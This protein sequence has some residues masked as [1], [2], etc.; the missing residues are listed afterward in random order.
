MSTITVY[1]LMVKRVAESSPQDKCMSIWEEYNHQTGS[2]ETP[3]ETTTK[4]IGIGACAG[5]GAGAGAATA[6][7]SFVDRRKLIP[8]DVE[9]V[10]I[11][12]AEGQ[13]Y[14]AKIRGRGTGGW[15]PFSKVGGC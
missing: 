10:L 15:T 14:Q 3:R 2:L 5:A 12:G 1:H 13:R 4:T 11:Q 8:R 6:T 7:A 9:S